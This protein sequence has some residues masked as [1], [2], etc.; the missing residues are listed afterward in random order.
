VTLRGPRIAEEFEALV[1]AY[2]ARRF[3]GVGQAA[4]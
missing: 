3:G 1:E 2:V 4:E